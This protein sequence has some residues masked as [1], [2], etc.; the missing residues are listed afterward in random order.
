MYQTIKTGMALGV[1]LQFVDK[2]SH[3]SSNSEEQLCH[4]PGLFF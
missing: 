1:T 4:F 2:H 3:A